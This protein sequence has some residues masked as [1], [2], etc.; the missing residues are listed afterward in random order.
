LQHQG[1]V[2]VRCPAEARDVLREGFDLRIGK[3]AG[4][5]LHVAAR[6]SPDAKARERLDD[7][8]VLLSGYRRRDAPAREIALVTR[9]A[10]RAVR[11]Q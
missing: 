8:L 5:F 11:D 4:R 1:G 3:T 9:A 6:T 10:L 7:V 2:A